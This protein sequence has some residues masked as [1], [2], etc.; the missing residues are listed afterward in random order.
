MVLMSDAAHGTEEWVAL[1]LQFSLTC[2]I[3]GFV[4]VVLLFNRRR[5]VML[6]YVKSFITL[7]RPLNAVCL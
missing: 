3:L 2:L 7:R 5:K 6:M 4:C 1:H